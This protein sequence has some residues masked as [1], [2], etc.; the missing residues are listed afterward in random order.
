MAEGLTEVRAIVA[1]LRGKGVRL[2]VMGGWGEELAGLAPPRSHKD[3]D[4]L[5]CAEDVAA[6]DSLLE[7]DDIEEFAVK[8]TSCSRA[9]DVGDLFV[10]C[11]LAEHDGAGWFTDFWGYE[12][13]WPADT[14]A[15]TGEFPIAGRESLEGIKRVWPLVEQA[16]EARYR[17]E[18]W[19]LTKAIVEIF[20]TGSL[21]RIEDLLVDDY[22]DHQGLRGRQI[23]GRDGFRAVVA[24]A[25]SLRELEVTIEDIVADDD[26]AA[27]R[28]R[29]RGVDAA[30]EPSERRTLDFLRF[31]DGRLAEHWGARIEP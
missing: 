22:L 2:Q 21:D 13:R 7:D 26:T 29:W 25:R 12:R 23:H 17:T 8:R 16:Y 14:F 30:G 1:R 15:D 31:R 3:L 24:A 28:L 5:C 18:A 20:A 10:D 19:A 27:V 6:L 9:F 4:L 11:Y